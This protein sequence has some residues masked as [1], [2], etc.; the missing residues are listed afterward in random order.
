MNDDCISKIY[1]NTIIGL[2]MDE[3]E[4]KEYNQRKLHENRN[5]D[6]CISCGGLPKPDDIIKAMGLETYK[7]RREDIINRFLYEEEDLD[8]CAIKF[9]ELD[10]GYLFIAMGTGLGFE[11]EEFY[12]VAKKMMPIFV[13]SLKKE[14]SGSIMDTYYQRVIVKHLFEK[15]LSDENGNYQRAVVLL[16]DDVD[17]SGFGIDT[18]KMYVSLFENMEAVYFD[19]FN[20][21]SVRKRCRSCIE[22]AEKKIETIDVPFVKRGLER[23][24]ILSNGE[25]W[26]AISAL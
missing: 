16:F 11:N 12:L 9:D 3:W 25:L 23:I 15:E 26:E 19:S 4:H 20:K 21:P 7:S 6:Y 2:A 5:K 8:V 24:L 1:F 18:I 10:P 14:D 13:R 17:Y 22:Y